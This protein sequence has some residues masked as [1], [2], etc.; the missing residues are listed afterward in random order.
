MTNQSTLEFVKEIDK[1]LTGDEVRSDYTPIITALKESRDRLDELLS[2][3]DGAYDVVE[4]HPATVG[5]YNSEW[6][7]RWLEKAR[8]HGA[9]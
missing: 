7:K 6:K 2:M 5:T 4:I 3:V 1:L 8:K 9:S